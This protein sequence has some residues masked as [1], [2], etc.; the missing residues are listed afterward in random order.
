LGRI[1]RRGVSTGA[2]KLIGFGTEIGFVFAVLA[3][4]VSVVSFPMLL[5]RP[6]RRPE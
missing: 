2:W 5:D 1:I 4:S 3:L 6:I